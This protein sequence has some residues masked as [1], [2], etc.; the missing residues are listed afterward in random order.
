MRSLLTVLCLCAATAEITSLVVV[1]SEPTWKPIFPYTQSAAFPTEAALNDLEIL[2]RNLRTNYS[3]FLETDD[4]AYH[5]KVCES[6]SCTGGLKHLVAGLGVPES[7][8]S[9]SSSLFPTA[10]TCPRLKYLMLRDNLDTTI[11]K[12]L[13]TSGQSVFHEL[14]QRN[15]NVSDVE[16]LGKY[17]E[18]A[19]LGGDSGVLSSEAKDWLYKYYAHF[20]GNLN[21]GQFDQGKMLTFKLVTEILGLM[22]S[23]RTLGLYVVPVTTLTALLKIFTLFS[24][25]PDYGTAF[26]LTL[27]EAMEVSFYLTDHPLA[28]DYCGNP[29]VFS[30]LSEKLR[31]K[32]MFSSAESLEQVCSYLGDDDLSWAKYY[33]MVGLLLVLWAFFKGSDWLVRRT[34]PKPKQE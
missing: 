11:H 31:T 33:W 25:V 19:V 15:I 27:N 17:A 8:Q 5:Y 3:D 21:V 2:G 30:A 10:L 1:L 6:A 22:E 7:A 13:M 9:V 18:Y 12:D 4:L 28:N 34:A 24:A 23:K 26:I 29:C 14:V 20:V 16:T 32:R